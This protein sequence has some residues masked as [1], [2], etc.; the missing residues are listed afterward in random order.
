MTEYSGKYGLLVVPTEN[1]GDD[2]Q[3]LAAWQFL[4]KVDVIIDRDYIDKVRLNEEVKIIMNGWFTYR[5]RSWPPPRVFRP[6]FISLHITPKAAN[7]LLRPEVIKYLRN[8]E[9]GARDLY[10]LKLLESK[11]IN[12]YFS[13]C[14]TLTLNYKLKHRV[15]RGSKILIVDLNEEAMKHLPKKVLEKAEIS[16]H[17]LL[18]K[19]ET[20]LLTKAF[21]PLNLLIPRTHRPLL[22]GLKYKLNHLLSKRIMIEER[23]RRAATQ[24]VKLAS[25]KLVITS[26]LHAAL[27]ATAF[28]TPVIFVTENPKKPRYRGLL[29]FVN[30]FTIK[31]FKSIVRKID[32][33]SPMR[34]PNEDELSK[35]KRELIRKV[36]KFINE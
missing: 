14:L 8:Y 13:G 28:R 31:E 9:V 17:Y 35:L 23:L 1:L 4:P 29:R 34:N 24:I 11:R 2:I 20:F 15:R 26:R 27:P 3:T 22:S 10:T 19:V 5:P 30:H 6:L 36:E 32:W 25:A 33:N 16:T 7:K 18:N 12:V 21:I